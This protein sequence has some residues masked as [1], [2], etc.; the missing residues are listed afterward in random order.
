MSDWELAS[1]LGKKSDYAASYDATLLQAVP[2]SLQRDTL[3]LAGDP[4]FFGV[5]Y[6]NLYELSWLN[7]QGKPVVA[8]GRFAVDAYS[9]S[10]IESKS[11]KLYL[12]SF[13]QTRFDSM[14]LVR[15]IIETD[16]RE[17]L[18][19]SDLTLELW[20]LNQAPNVF[21]ELPGE[22][23]DDLEVTIESYDYD[24]QI[25]SLFSDDISQQVFHSRLLKSNC[26]VTGQP[27]W[28]SVLISFEGKTLDK[29]S[30]LRYLISF[31]CHQEFHEHCAER[32]FTDIWQLAKPSQLSVQAYY[33]RR[34]GIDINP[35]RTHRS[36]SIL[37]TNPLSRLVRQ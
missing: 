3:N 15:Q 6:W 11:L 17:C 1:A 10:L 37:D 7:S 31:R 18:E 16:L 24:P 30:L 36:V 28:G 34:G 23:L 12:N 14:D 29:Y 22:C 26:L 20:A 32:I 5:D 19:T 8:M 9:V 35:L 21:S 25:L 4:P 13:N 2:R 33:T 27:D